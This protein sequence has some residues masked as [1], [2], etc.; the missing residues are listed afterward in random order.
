[1]AQSREEKLLF[2]TLNSRSQQLLQILHNYEYG[3]LQL[4][5]ELAAALGT[6]PLTLLAFACLGTK[7][8]CEEIIT[9]VDRTILFARYFKRAAQLLAALREVDP[10]TT[11][12]VFLPDL[13]PRRTWGWQVPQD[14]ITLACLIMR[15]EAQ[16][17]A[18]FTLHLW[19]EVETE[20]AGAE[21]ETWEAAASEAAQ[22]TRPQLLD[23]ETRFFRELGARHPDIL[24]TGRP[25]EIALKQL[26]AY[27][28]EGCVLE[29]LFPAGCLLQADVP[30]ERRDPM[31][32]A[33]RHTPL[34]ILHPLTPE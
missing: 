24:I 25:R 1:M 32:Q 7:A 12:H 18:G 33:L 3:E 14:D 31:F 8:H 11:L 2:R 16:L 21:D 9:Q 20:F 30:R 29:R 13:E 34:P 15:D 28:H 26:G 23:E 10:E 19:S 6:A 4:T 22:Y 17:P 27:A 5:P